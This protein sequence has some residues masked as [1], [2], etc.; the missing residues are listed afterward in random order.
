MG[1]KGMYLERGLVHYFYIRGTGNVL[2][3]LLHSWQ[4]NRHNFSLIDLSYELDFVVC[5]CLVAK[6]CLTL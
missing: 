5:F 4:R 2:K 3:A 6:S 1:L